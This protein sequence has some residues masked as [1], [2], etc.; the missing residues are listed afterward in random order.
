MDELD[1]HPLDIKC[2]IMG[3]SGADHHLSA[4]GLKAFPYSTECK[5]V[6][7][8]NVWD[9]IK[10]AEKVRLPGTTPLL[11]IKRNGTQP[12][13]VLNF[14]AFLQIQKRLNDADA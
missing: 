5:N 4:A 10:Q 9:A 12:H 11:I 13:V 1:V 14:E 6:E 2:A 7:R 3:E 8:L